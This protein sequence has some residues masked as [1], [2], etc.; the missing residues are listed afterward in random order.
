M[1]KGIVKWFNSQKGYGFIT[2]EDATD[3]FVHYS[4]IVSEQKFKSIAEGQTV[5]FEITDG[6]KGKQAINVTVVEETSKEVFEK[7][8]DTINSSTQKVLSGEA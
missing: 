4:G 3:I 2:M 8:M 5:E 7:M 1:N 6:E